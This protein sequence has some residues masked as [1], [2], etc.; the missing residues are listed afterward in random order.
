L[1]KIRTLIPVSIE[2]VILVPSAIPLVNFSSIDLRIDSSDIAGKRSGE[3]FDKSLDEVLSSISNSN[4]AKGF[5]NVSLEGS[6]EVS[7]INLARLST[8]V[9]VILLVR[10]SIDI[11]AKASAKASLVSAEVSAEA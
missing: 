10:I 3:S 6:A 4:L 5:M 7:T 11:S 9:C 8:K 1:A 2:V